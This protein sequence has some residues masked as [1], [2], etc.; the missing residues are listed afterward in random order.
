MV[1]ETEGIRVL[2]PDEQCQTWTGP[3]QT[4]QKGS[5]AV[6]EALAELGKP[7]FVVGSNGDTGVTN[8][9]ELGSSQAQPGLSGRAFAPALLPEQLGDPLFCKTYGTRYAY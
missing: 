9:G 1:S 8:A 5:A 7:V 6:R 4:V 2:S 3:V